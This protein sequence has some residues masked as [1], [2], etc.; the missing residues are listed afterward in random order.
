M[1]KSTW[2]CIKN[3]FYALTSD[4]LNEKKEKRILIDNPYKK[5]RLLKLTQDLYIIYEISWKGLLLKKLAAVLP[6][7]FYLI[8]R[9]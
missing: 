4:M 7:I 1:S 2:T 5:S 3:I 8:S 9:S 6:H